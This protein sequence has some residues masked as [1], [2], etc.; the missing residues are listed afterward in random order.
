MSMYN[1]YSPRPS[2]G[3]SFLWAFLLLAVVAALV[4]WRIWPQREPATN[5]NAAPRPVA[6]R[7]DLA[8]DEKT[9]IKIYKEASPSV[10]NVNTLGVL[11]DLFGLRSQEIPRGTGSGFVWDE[12]GR[13][14]TNNHV[15][16]A[17]NSWTV[18]LWDRSTW[19]AR[20]V[21]RDPAM[22]LAVLQ[23]D[24]P[25]NRLHPMLIGKS[26]D[27]QVG[28]KVFAIGNPFGLDQT[29]TQGIVSALG[30][31]IAEEEGRQPIKGAIQTDAP[32]NPGN[33]G[34][35][36]LDSSGRL[37]GVN[38]AIISPSKASAGIGFAIP[39]DE[40]NRVVP[41]LIRHGKVYRPGLGIEPVPEQLARRWGIDGVV[42]LKVVP[43]GPAAKA[44]LRGLQRDRQGHIHLGD[45]IV[46]IGEHEVHSPNEMY[47]ILEKYQI[48]DTVTVR[49]DRDDERQDTQ[50][51]LGADA[52]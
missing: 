42:I 25:K 24:A 44:G 7:G 39:V 30:R 1:R 34:G 26:S 23:I 18:S 50:V 14:V 51:T 27:L 9:N 41:Q 20:L 36:L 43:G 33:S 52:R 31:E 37:I 8:E 32:I 13:V 22:D 4:V 15:I 10:V 46:A 45:V 28:Q 38:T 3:L 29:M 47:T 17:G 19:K 21:G 16:E 11:K 35:P 12:D 48:G 6:A 49:I 2:H 5:P 40:V